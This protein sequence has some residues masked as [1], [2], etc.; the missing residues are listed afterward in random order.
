LSDKFGEGI[1]LLPE[2][3]YFWTEYNHNNTL[4]RVMLGQ[5]W[6]RRNEMV[7]I[8]IKPNENLTVYENL[9]N[10]LN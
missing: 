5:K 2:Y 3:M 4:D 1:K 8:D 9:R 6:I 10:N 7:M